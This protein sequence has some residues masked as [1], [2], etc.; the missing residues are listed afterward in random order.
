MS[1]FKNQ[2]IELKILLANI[3]NKLKNSE[4]ECPYKLL[5]S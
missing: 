3:L 5:G 1:L 2:I 4:Q